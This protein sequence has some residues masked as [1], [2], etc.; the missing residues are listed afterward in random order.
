MSNRLAAFIIFVLSLSLYLPSIHN[1]FAYDDFVIIEVNERVHDL[2]HI[3]EILTGTYWADDGLGLYRPIASLS[4]AVDWTLSH[5]RPGWFHFVNS[6]WNAFTCVVLF[7]LLVAFVPQAAA[8][9]ATLIYAAHPVHVEAVANVVGRAEVMAAFFTL[10][11]MLIWQ[12]SDPEQPLPRRRLAGVAALYVLALGSKE[13][14]I[15]LPA[16]LA[17]VDVARGVLRPDNIT[18]WFRRHRAPVIVLGLL[19]AVYMVIRQMIVGSIG[20]ELVDPTLDVA[21]TTFTR[22]NT[23]MQAWPI[24]ARLLFYP[25]LLLSDYGPRITMPM[26]APT[27]QSMLGLAMFLAL[28]L[29]GLLAWERGRARLAFVLLFMPVSLLPVSNIILPIGVLVS[30]RGLYLASVALAAAIA[31][32]ADHYRERRHVRSILATSTIAVLA[33]FS[34]RTLIR[35]PEWKTTT[36]IFDALR[37]DRPDNFRGQ[38][39][40]SRVAVDRKE[41]QLALQRFQHTLEIWPY[42]ERVTVEAAVFAAHAGALTFARDVSTFAMQRWPE[43]MDLVRVHAGV[44]L[45]LADTATAR[46][47]IEHGL[48]VEPADTILLKMRAAIMPRTQK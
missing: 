22:I 40:L 43:N 36:S 20:P 26:P 48:R 34:A 1:R 44:A 10:C 42:R 23:A 2:A 29:G 4:Y 39:H 37:R 38:W 13:N 8:L 31:F 15:M 35:I 3:D 24:V 11:A 33:L 32:L 5:G 18:A 46:T 45:D 30:E 47:T 19:A 7:L 9:A 25:R 12:R 21:N 17:L 16:L 27:L 14:A 28:A 6:L 41:N